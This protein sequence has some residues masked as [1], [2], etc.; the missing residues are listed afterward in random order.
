MH[1]VLLDDPVTTA[2]T[3]A[4]TTGRLY[5]TG[6]NP[7]PAPA[8]VDP[9]DPAPAPARYAVDAAD[10]DPAPAPTDAPDD[11]ADPAPYDTPVPGIIISYIQKL[12]F[13]NKF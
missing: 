13:L 2:A 8:P 12:N 4:D 1:V 11:P 10:P 7:P 6:G 9:A 5:D 3:S